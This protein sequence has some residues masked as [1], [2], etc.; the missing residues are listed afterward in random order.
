MPAE[1][2]SSRTTREAEAVFRVQGVTKVYQMGEVQV[3]ALRGIDLDLYR[4]EFAVMLG[5]S[6]SG[7]SSLVRAG[8]VP[9]IQRGSQLPNGTMPPD[10][11]PPPCCRGSRCRRAVH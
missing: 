9:A 2:Q 1:Q 5:A 8:L 7:K 10:S 3:H 4:G 6:G 11:S